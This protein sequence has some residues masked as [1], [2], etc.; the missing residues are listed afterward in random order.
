MRNLSRPVSIALVGLLSLSPLACDSVPKQALHQAQTTTY[1]MHQRNQIL[2]V[3]RDQYN[4]VAQQSMAQL[5]GMQTQVAGMQTQFAGMQAQSEM[6][7]AENSGLQHTVGKLTHELTVSNE[8]LNNLT[9]ERGELQNRYVGLLKQVKDV[10]SPLSDETRRRFE[11]LSRKYPN[12]A[13]DPITG[14]SKF[15]S[16]IL[17]D[18]GSAELK[19]TA[20]PLLREFAAVMNGGGGNELNIL[21]VGHTDDKDIIK[22]GTASQHPTNWHLSTNRANAV[23]LAL[24]HGGVRE[25]RMGVSGYSKFLPAAANANETG[26]QQNRRVEIFVMAPDAVVAGWERPGLMRR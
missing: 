22:P 24:A 1:A 14:A 26:R 15:H 23:A 13:F 9:A 2:A 5:Q 12:F 4:M 11:E 10:P 20:I 21:I 8:R 7:Q 17:F 19:P 16:D 3:E 18:S 25:H 6:L